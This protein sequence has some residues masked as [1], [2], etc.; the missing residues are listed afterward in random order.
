MHHG[1]WTKGKVLHL[2][3]R[4]VSCDKARQSFVTAIMHAKGLSRDISR[5][6]TDLYEFASTCCTTQHAAACLLVQLPD[7]L[8][9]EAVIKPAMDECSVT[10]AVVAQN[11]LPGELRLAPHAPSPGWHAFSLLILL[12]LV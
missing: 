9:L 1:Q 10:V 12:L 3:L 6:Q 8:D 4:V 2:W 11:Q 7:C 5:V